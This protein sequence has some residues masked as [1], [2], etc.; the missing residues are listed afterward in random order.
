[1]VWGALMATS[2]LSWGVTA[3]ATAGALFL[4]AFAACGTA[5][6]V[7]SSNPLPGSGVT[8]G[9]EDAGID[10]FGAWPREAPDAALPDAGAISFGDDGAVPP[11]RFSCTGKTGPG[12]DTTLT[13][14]SAGILRDALVHVPPSYDPTSGEMLVLNFHGYS[15]NAPEEEILAEMNPV[16]DSRGFMVVYPDGVDSSWNAG[17]CCGVAWNNSVDD[18]AFTQNLI[19][20]LESQYCIDPSRVYATGMSNGGFFAHRLGCEMASTF[21]AIA[22]VAGVMGIPDDTCLPS[23]PMPVLDF[24]GTANPI[25]PYDGGGAVSGLGGTVVVFQ[26]VAQTIS[27]W[28]A[29]DSCSTPGKT[30]YAV[31]DATCVD[32]DQ[33]APGGEVVMCTIAGGGHTWPGGVPIPLGVTSPDISATDTMIDFFLAHPM[34]PGAL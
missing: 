11:S 1:M 17:S 10:V 32:Y 26:S 14:T 6:S 30:I 22:P 31:G 23:R 15:S 24:H 8:S 3:L 29:R 25:V 9:A 16:A 20:D 34:P 28:L 13:L 27:T 18:V 33:C 21:A 7:E 4:F 12:G 5:A 19:A 2:R